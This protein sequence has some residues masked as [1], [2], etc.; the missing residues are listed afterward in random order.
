MSLARNS[1]TLEVLNSAMRGLPIPAPELPEL[2]KSAQA[3]PQGE[4]TAT[5]T[6][7][8]TPALPLGWTPEKPAAEIGATFSEKDVSARKGAAPKIGAVAPFSERML[9]DLV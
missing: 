6:A 4:P 9:R 7:T 8:K 1:V 2:P 3:E 5:T